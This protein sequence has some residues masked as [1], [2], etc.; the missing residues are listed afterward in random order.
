[1]LR[2]DILYDCGN[3]LNPVIDV[4]Q[5][6]GAFVMGQGYFMQEEILQ[7]FDGVLASEDTWEHEPRAANI[8]RGVSGAEQAPGPHGSL[9]F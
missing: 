1:V 3:S 8:P 2:S 4:G 7:G 5:A 9:G 6:E